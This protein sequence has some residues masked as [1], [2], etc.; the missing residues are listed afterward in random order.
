MEGY[1]SQTPLFGIFF[2]IAALCPSP[3]LNP[4]FP[5]CFPQY[6]DYYLLY[7]ALLHYSSL[8]TMSNVSTAIVHNNTQLPADAMKDG[9]NHPLF[10]A[11]IDSALNNC[12]YTQAFVKEFIVPIVYEAEDGSFQAKFFLDNKVAERLWSGLVFMS[13]VF[14][15]ACNDSDIIDPATSLKSYPSDCVI[16]LGDQHFTFRHHVLADPSKN[17]FLCTPFKSISQLV[18]HYRNMQYMVCQY[19]KWL[20]HAVKV[21]LLKGFRSEFNFGAYWGLT[22]AQFLDLLAPGVFD[23]ARDRVE[24]RARIIKPTPETTLDSSKALILHPRFSRIAQVFEYNPHDPTYRLNGPIFTPI[25]EVTKECEAVHA[26][27]ALD[28]LVGAA[29]MSEDGMKTGGAL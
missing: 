23:E 5:V 20:G 27:L 7:S 3:Y 25:A 6:L 21:S 16:E 1:I 26:R 17:P 12:I 9:Y 10:K 11:Y 29:N 18:E 8:F 19:A 15:T 2:Q 24:G 28:P 4:E 14:I 13:R 22:K